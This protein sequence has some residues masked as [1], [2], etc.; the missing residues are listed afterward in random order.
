MTL[1]VAI[2]VT[3]VFA[4]SGQTWLKLKKVASIKRAMEHIKTDRSK[5]WSGERA[6]VLLLHLALPLGEQADAIM[7]FEGLPL[8]K[9][10]NVHFIQAAS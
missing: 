2:A 7:S 4:I 1:H 6:P 5:S 10:K 3:Q 9:I 8:V